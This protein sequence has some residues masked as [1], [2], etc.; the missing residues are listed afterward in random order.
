MLLFFGNIMFL[1]FKVKRYIFKKLK[2]VFD[3]SC[4]YKGKWNVGINWFIKI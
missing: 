2:N 3:V 4:K 1:V